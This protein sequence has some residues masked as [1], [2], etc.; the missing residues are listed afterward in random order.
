MSSDTVSSSRR[1]WIMR[2]VRS[3]NTTPELYVRRTLH[4]AGFRFRIHNKRLPG[5]PDLVLTKYRTVIF[6]QGCFWHWHGCRRSRMP[7]SNVEYWQRK[8]ARNVERDAKNFDILSSMGWHV[9]IVWECELV[10][11]TADLIAL[12]P[13]FGQTPKK[14]PSSNTSG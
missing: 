14:H 3:K 4:A 1:S 2:Q 8:I 11:S 9:K 12:L 10:S 13:S 7:S 6:V 5:S